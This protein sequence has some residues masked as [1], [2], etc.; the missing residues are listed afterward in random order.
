MA[1]SAKE[2]REA[3][4]KRA[5]KRMAKTK[6]WMFKNPTVANRK[7]IRRAEEQDGKNSRHVQSF[8]TKGWIR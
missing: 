7:D 2:Q 1:L 5:E 3:Q 8:L 4:K 6:Q